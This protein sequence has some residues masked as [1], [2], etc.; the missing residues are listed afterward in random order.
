MLESF[1]ID[2]EIIIMYSFIHLKLKCIDHFEKSIHIHK[3]LLHIF[4]KFFFVEKNDPKLSH[5]EKM[6]SPHL[7]NRF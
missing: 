3:N 5:Y 1:K 4:Q 7:S 6:E 2:Y